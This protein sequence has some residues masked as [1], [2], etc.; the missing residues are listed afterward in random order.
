[1][2]PFRSPARGQFAESAPGQLVGAQPGR[3]REQVEVHHFQTQVAQRH[4]GRHVVGPYA[5]QAGDC[6]ADRV[7][8]LFQNREQ[9]PRHPGE[10]SLVLGG[11]HEY[12][13]SGGC[14][15]CGER[16]RLLQDEVGVGASRAER[17]DTRPPDAGRSRLPWCR[18][19]LEPERAVVDAQRRVHVVAVQRGGECAVP[20]LEQHLGH[21]GHPG[22]ALQVADDRLDRT[23]CAGGVDT[24]VRVAQ[25]LDLD[26]VTERGAGAV[27]LDV[28]DGGRVDPGC[29]QGA[30]HDV[31][32][33]ARTGHGEPAGPA[34]VVEAGA[35]DHAVHVVAVGPRCGERLEQQCA[36][37]LAGHVTRAAPAETAA[38]SVAREPLPGGE[39]QV[40]LRVRH[41]VHPARQG[42]G[43]LARAD[44]LHGEVDRRQR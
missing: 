15:G 6:P 30:G 19:A 18:G 1:M 27:R 10:L 8:V 23:E 26:R 12:G 44:G 9:V 39:L 20:Q 22:G 38:S 3:C 17:T 11:Q 34:T 16:R 21:G 35:A 25:S 24:C 4:G 28:G 32:L 14:G 42:P 36:H 31:G 2:Q 33:R 37:T 43:A 5:E 40:L 41:D 13:R 7:V 29:G